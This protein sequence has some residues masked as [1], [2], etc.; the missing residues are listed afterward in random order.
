MNKQL[1]DD[2]EF[3]AAGMSE[4]A[5]LSKVIFSHGKGSYLYDING[6]K[7]LDFSIGIFTNSLGQCHPK[8][9]EAQKKQIS[10]LGNIHDYPC[11]IRLELL[12]LLYNITPKYINNFAFCSTGAEAVELALRAIYTYINEEDIYI[13]T[14]EDGYHGKTGGIRLISDWRYR[15]EPLKKSIK[16]PYPKCSKCPFSKCKENCNF[17]CAHYISDLFASNPNIKVFIFEPILGAGGIHIAPKEYW[18]IVSEACKKYEVLMI[19]DEIFV[20]G[21]KIGEFF[22]CDYYN[23]DPDIIL[24]SKGISS[25]YPFS[26]VAGRKEILSNKY[27]S[28]YGDVSST[29]ASHPF[30]IATALSTINIIKEEKLIDNVKNLSNLINEKCEELR[31]NYSILSDIRQ[32]GFLFAFEFDGYKEHDKYKIAQMFFEKCLE[33]GLKVSLGGNIIRM[34]PPMNI[35]K[36]ELE[37]AF[38]I[39]QV[40]LDKII[41]ED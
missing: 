37:E 23:I 26:V 15:S 17:E 19:D 2:R 18:K 10:K 34:S 8:L 3:Y 36:S 31:L 12:K 21:G 28:N 4:E 41:E 6:K 24:M 30:G 33:N 16:V 22:A 9:V 11:D 35:T 27:F 20:S 7:Y 39:I 5:I 29:Y 25:G 40:V 13:L 32:I 1:L 14:F 38:N